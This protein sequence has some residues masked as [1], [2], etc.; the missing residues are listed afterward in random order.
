MPAG[1][2]LDSVEL[3]EDPHLWELGFFRKMQKRERGW[4]IG[5]IAIYACLAFLLMIL[6][7]P[8]TDR[9]SKKG[10]IPTARRRSPVSARS[11]PEV[12]VVRARS[13]TDF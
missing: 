12:S 3:H 13:V 11:D 1:P 4:I 8:S 6:L 7:N 10:S 2:V 5:L 9:Q